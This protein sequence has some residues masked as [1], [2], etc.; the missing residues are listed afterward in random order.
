VRRRSRATSR[1][2]GSR[3]DVVLGLDGFAN[4]ELRWF[5]E[6]EI[7]PVPLAPWLSDLMRSVA[8]SERRFAEVRGFEIPVGAT[9]AAPFANG[10]WPAVTL[11]CVDPERGTP[12][13]YHLPT[14]TPENLETEK[15]PMCIDSRSA[16]S[17]PSW[18]AADA[19]EARAGRRACAAHA[20]RARRSSVFARRGA[21]SGLHSR[22]CDDQANNVGGAALATAALV[23]LS[24][25]SSSG[26]TGG[27]GGDGGSGGEGGR[28]SGVEGG[29][30]LGGSIN[31]PRPPATPSWIGSARPPR[32]VAGRACSPY[33]RWQMVP[34]G[35]KGCVVWAP[36]GWIVDGAWTA[37]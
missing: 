31:P 3:E 22:C 4:G 8:A 5:T 23:A 21:A 33:R 6:G 24:C 19:S 2:A 18:R 37:P 12:R 20:L 29:A 9:D 35:D 25:S 30:T 34:I 14:D 27:S 7:F 32:P 10:G 17:R 1:T 28:D 11:G 16:S 13:H 36:P 15:I 26:G